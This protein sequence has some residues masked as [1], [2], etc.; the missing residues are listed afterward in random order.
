MVVYEGRLKD[1]HRAS[2]ERERERERER[3]ILDERKQTPRA[4]YAPPCI[5]MMSLG[6]EKTDSF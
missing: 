3:A 1:M 6:E 4:G 5:C 2:K